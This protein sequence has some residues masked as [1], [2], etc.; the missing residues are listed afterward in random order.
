MARR[1]RCRLVVRCNGV[2]YLDEAVIIAASSSGWFTH[3]GFLLGA[4]SNFSLRWRRTKH[5]TE[6]AVDRF[7][8]PSPV[9]RRS[10]NVDVRPLETAM[11]TLLKSAL[12]VVLLAA[13]VAFAQDPEPA[14][15]DRYLPFQGTWKLVAPP[16]VTVPPDT[17]IP[18]VFVEVTRNEFTLRGE[19]V[20]TKI[21]FPLEFFIPSGDEDKPYRQMA[22]EGLGN[23][24]DIADIENQIVV[25]WFVGI[26][27]LDNGV[28]ELRLKYVGQ[29][30]EFEAYRGE[31]ARNAT[32]PSSFSNRVPDG[33]VQIFLER[34]GEPRVIEKRDAPKL[35]D[36]P[37]LESRKETKCRWLTG[38]H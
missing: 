19:G 23:L 5:S 6:A 1:C 31:A 25:F 37:S 24:E 35:L 10:V 32:L 30:S 18:E 33:E 20:R 9:G 8:E 14:V 11:T 22:E 28:L 4:R 17:V 26:Y 7:L 21:E 15:E 13:R 29:G 12:C 2:L 3:K 16:D 38:G 36:A 27:K 34:V